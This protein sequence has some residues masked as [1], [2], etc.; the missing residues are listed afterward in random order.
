[1]PSWIIPVNFLGD[2]VCVEDLVESVM[3]VQGTRGSR[4]GHQGGDGLQIQRHH[5][6]ICLLSVHQPPLSLNSFTPCVVM[7]LLI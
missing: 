2:N 4:P 7:G 3:E 5:P 1:M 6:D